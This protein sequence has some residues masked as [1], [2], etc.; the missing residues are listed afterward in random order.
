MT[1][2]SQIGGN[3]S[4]GRI[5][6]NIDVLKISREPNQAISEKYGTRGCNC[7]RAKVEE[8]LAAALSH[9]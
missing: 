9:E 1:C 5:G 2:S 7:A 3:L 6:P 4:I 8:H